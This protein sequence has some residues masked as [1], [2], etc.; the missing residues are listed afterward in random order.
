[1]QINVLTVGKPEKDFHPVISLYEKKCSRYFN[2]NL[3]QLRDVR[4][5]DINGKIK[6]EE[7]IILNALPAGFHC[8]LDERGK[9]LN[10]LQFADF[11]KKR[12]E[13]STDLNFII[14]G[15]YG[16]SQRVKDKADIAVRLS[17]FTLQHDVAYIVLLEQIY[18]ALT[19]L[20][21]VPYH[22]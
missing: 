1:M 3:I 20:K 6:E 22:K 13:N 18:R 10:T 4:I 11:I 16:L 2:V 17:D 14:G 8:I 15:A 21:N 12:Q 7:N 5:K 19:I 9:N